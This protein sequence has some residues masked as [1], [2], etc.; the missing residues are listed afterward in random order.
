MGIPKPVYRGKRKYGWMITLLLFIAAAL[1]IAGVW[2][3]YD[4]QNYIEY[5]KDGLRLVFD[6]PGDEILSPAED[7]VVGE[8]VTNPQVVIALPDLEGV[9]NMV[10]STLQPIRAMYVKGEN[11]KADTLAYYPGILAESEVDYNALV[12]SIKDEEGFLRYFST[13]SLASSYGVNGT[14]KLEESLAALKEKDIRLVAEL[15]CLVDN[16]MAVRNSPIALKDVSGNVLSNEQGSWLD[17][18]SP[19]VREY[20]SGLMAELAKMGFD[21]ILF[22]NMAFPNMTAQFSQPMTA[23]PDGLS[24]VAALAKYLRGCADELG[25]CISAQIDGKALREGSSAA[26]GQD[27]EFFL[28]M[29]DRLYLETDFDHYV[30]DAAILGELAGEQAESR[31][32]VS[33]EGFT[34]QA[35]SFFTK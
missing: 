26:V 8:P 20:L 29:F 13:L 30:S 21:E 27:A 6:D 17:P 32:V 18:Y 11:I 25:I 7:V 31:V 34:P 1:L 22:T 35:D 33:V 9:E 3:F 5:E 16:A 10:H 2:L 14:E 4:L 23:A 28:K 12:L 19:A 24:S 15:S